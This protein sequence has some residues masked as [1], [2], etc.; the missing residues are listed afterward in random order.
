MYGRRWHQ[1]NQNPNSPRLPDATGGHGFQASR[2]CLPHRPAAAWIKV[3]NR[4][5]PSLDR[6]KDG[7]GDSPEKNTLGEMRA[8]GVRGLLVYCAD[9]KCAHLARITGDRWPDHIRVSDLE[10][11]FVCQACGA[12]GADIRAR[13]RL[14]QKAFFKLAP[15]L[16]T[17]HAGGLI[18]VGHQARVPDEEGRRWFSFLRSSS[19][20]EAGPLNLRN[21]HFVS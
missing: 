20:R 5:H 8:M 18:L 13:L 3:K 4:N 12:R 9:Y 7:K 14:G 19:A 15:P 6:I 2:P 11:L 10:E 21:S 1:T 17:L 16:H